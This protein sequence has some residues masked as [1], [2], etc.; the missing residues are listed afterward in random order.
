V[1]FT[2]SSN[3]N[4]PPGSYTAWFNGIEVFDNNQDENF[5]PAVRLVWTIIEGQLRGQQ[6]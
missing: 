6:A 2:Y 1:K 4:P 3:E 5:G